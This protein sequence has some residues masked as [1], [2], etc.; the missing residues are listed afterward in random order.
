MSL[1]LHQHIAPLPAYAGGP[2]GAAR[3]G[4]TASL[5]QTCIP[6][7]S[8]QSPQTA[9]KKRNS[10][11]SRCLRRPGWQGN[12]PEWPAAGR[13]AHHVLVHDPAALPSQLG[14]CFSLWLEI[15]CLL[16]C[17]CTQA[18]TWHDAE[19]THS[20]WLLHQAALHLLLASGPDERP[21]CAEATGTSGCTASGTSPA[22]RRRSNSPHHRAPASSV[23]SLW[24]ACPAHVC[25]R[26]VPQRAEALHAGREA[27]RTVSPQLGTD[28]MLSMCAANRRAH[29][30]S[31]RHPPRQ[32]L[33]T[34]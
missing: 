31:A 13:L 7:P 2:W 10:Q 3:A 21:L 4:N 15:P 20:W 34:S 25:Q 29:Q 12:S 26:P 19:A 14:P 23:A 18:S 9:A 22:S 17:A 16:C 6:G 30:R 33:C 11:G 1:R 5:L 27:L 8:L 28:K 32:Q 24:L